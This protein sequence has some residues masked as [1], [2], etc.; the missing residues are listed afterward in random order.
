MVDNADDEEILFG[1]S[2]NGRGVAGY[3][4]QSRH[5]LTLFTTR[6][7]ETAVAL[8]GKHV[9]DLEQMASEEAETYF[10]R[11]LTQEDLLQDREVTEEL[12]TELTHLPLAIA[13]AAAYLN[14]RRL[15]LR[16]YLS[17][18]QS[19]EEDTISL[20]SRDFLDQTRSRGRGLVNIPD[21]DL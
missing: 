2:D 14:A 11:S 6:Y 21:G 12:L 15:S 3:L 19:T 16:E 18:L 4:P 5:G 13:Q 7:R 8:A 1:T 17:L 10:R 20:L 9:V